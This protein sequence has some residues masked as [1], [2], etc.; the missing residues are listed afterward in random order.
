MDLSS[1]DVFVDAGM[2]SADGSLQINAIGV[3]SGDG[4]AGSGTLDL[5]DPNTGDPV[6]G[7]AEI[8]FTATPGEL[9]E[10][11][12][13]SASYKTII[14]G[15]VIDVEGTL[16]FPGGHAFDLGPCIGT[17]TAGKS[18]SSSTGPKPGGKK[19]VNDE[20][21]GA[22][23]LQIGSRAT[24]STKGASPVAEELNP[25]S[26]YPGPDGEPIAYEVGHTVWYTITGTGGDVTIDTAG[27][28]FDTIIGVYVANGSG[29]DVVDCSDDE[30]YG[31]LDNGRT[32]QAALTFATT[33]GTTYYV[34]IGGFPD[35]VAY[36]TLRV[37][38]R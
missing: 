33:L 19:P 7:A 32:L 4:G 12:L 25:C 2:T 6:A 13:E 28:S 8:T 23:A 37:A 16:T 24:T 30:F 18:I 15:A 26:V 36:G 20:P 22:I 1:D 34:Q 27:S 35:P 14:S 21:S 9:F 10:Y 17:A 29:F 3:V 11:V 38:I 31:P 5:Y